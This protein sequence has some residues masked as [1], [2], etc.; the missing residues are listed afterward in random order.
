MDI[1]IKLTENQKKA[2]AALQDAVHTAIGYGGWAWGGKSYLWV[3]WV[4]LMCIKY[5][6]VRFALVR[7]T[8]KNLKNTTVVSLEKFYNDYNIPEELRWKLSEQKSLIT[9]KNWST[10]LLL[11]WCYYPS[12]PLYNRFWSLELTWAFVEE[13]AEVPLDAIKILTTRVWRY[14]NEQ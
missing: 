6:G 12:D 4:W 2:M 1:D 14:K 3:I 11:E 13:S 7:D 9:F 5:P 10:I 8:I